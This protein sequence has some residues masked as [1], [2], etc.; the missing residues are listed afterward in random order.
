M[1]G[2]V[3]LSG[4]HVNAYAF[5]ASTISVMNSR[6]GAIGDTTIRENEQY[7]T[8]GSRGIFLSSNE[9][10]SN[11]VKC[12]RRPSADFQRN[13]ATG[14]SQEAAPV[15]S[16]THVDRYVQPL[17]PSSSRSFVH[18]LG[19]GHAFL[20][21]G[22]STCMLMWCSSGK[23]SMVD[24]GGKASTSR[25][26]VASGRILL[27]PEVFGLVQANQ[28]KKGDVMTVAQL[29]GAV[30]DLDFCTIMHIAV[31]NGAAFDLNCNGL[32]CMCYL[33][34]IISGAGI[35]GAKHTS[36]LI[37]L[38]HNIPLNKI[39]VKLKLDPDS[40]SISIHGE[41]STTGQTGVEMEALTAVSTAALTVY[42]MCKAVSKDICIT[43]I[44]LEAKSGGQ[45]GKYERAKDPTDTKA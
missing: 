28:M 35:M 15:A 14:S 7:C 9:S 4:L 20:P 37:P 21:L 18:A 29:A 8:Q 36:L 31:R 23:A 43:D 6:S 33:F 25:V 11:L 27:G 40:S 39:G 42:D 3:V 38:C 32:K 22:A 26:A 13:H 34:S 19:S 10:P 1:S 24:V 45:S 2:C 5:Q 30:P 44:R 41:A 16:L 17:L 12:S